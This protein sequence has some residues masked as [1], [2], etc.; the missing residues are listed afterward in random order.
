M[1]RIFGLLIIAALSGCEK[2]IDFKLNQ[3]ANVLA[4]DAVIENNQPPVVV[5]TKSFGYFANISVDLVQNLY[6]HNAIVTISNGTLTHQL[7]EYAIPLG[8]GLNIYAYQIDSSSLSTAFAGEFDKIYSLK[9]ISEGQ[10]YNATTTIPLLA[11]KIDS[12]W[13]KQAPF[14]DDTSKIILMAKATDPPGLGNYVRYFTKN[15]SGTFLPGRNS[16]FNDEVIDGTTYSAEVDQGI[17]WNN[18]PKPDSNYFK[19]GDTITMK[20][21]NIDKGTYTFWSTWEFAAASIGN[22]FSQ[23][24]KILGNIS[25]GALGAFY[26]YA[27]YTKTLIVPR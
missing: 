6:V 17:D 4:V 7:K 1:K 26:G 8:P 15:N 16:V 21:S 23:P 24:G 14:Q 11:K 22:P 19:R 10:E 3:P 2:N 13:W 12:L 9:I 25:N 5:L 20:L 27:S 18:I